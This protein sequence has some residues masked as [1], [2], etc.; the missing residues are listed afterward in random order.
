VRGA[1]LVDA[2]RGLVKSFGERLPKCGTYQVNEKLA[3]GAN[4]ELRDVLVPLLR[5]VES[6]R[7]SLASPTVRHCNPFLFF[8]AKGRLF[9]LHLGVFLAACAFGM[10]QMG[11]IFL[12]LRSD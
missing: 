11:T 12:L 8:I 10:A 7:P 3:E 2:A 5:E 1:A 9:S 4:A 6:L